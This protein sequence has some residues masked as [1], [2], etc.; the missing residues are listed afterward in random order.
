MGISN[1]IMLVF[2][3]A[4]ILIVLMYFIKNTYVDYLVPSTRL[5][6]ELLSEDSNISKFEKFKGRLIMYIQLL[7]LILLVLM[8]SGLYIKDGAKIHTSSLIFIDNSIS[9][10]YRYEGK[11]NLEKAKAQ[12]LKLIDESI[13]GSS[14]LIIDA[15]GKIDMS[16]GK[17]QAARVIDNIYQLNS[18]L[19]PKA[20]NNIIGG[21][22]SSNP[23][24]YLIIFSNNEEIMGDRIYRYGSMEDN[25]AITKID[26][27]RDNYNIEITN[28]S[29][30]EKN[31]ELVIKLDA[32]TKDI[33]RVSLEPGQSKIIRGK[34]IGE[35]KLLSAKINLD[36]EIHIDNFASKTID[37]RE[38]L[39]VFLSGFSSTYL[40]EALLLN[41]NLSVS[42]SIDGSILNSGFDIYIYSGVEPDKLPK[43]GSMLLIN[44]PEGSKFTSSKVIEDMYVKLSSD[45]LNSFVE[46]FYVSKSKELN[47]NN[48]TNI[49]SLG[50]SPVIQKGK[51]G[52]LSLV[53]MGFD[54]MDT[55]LPLK[56][57]FP[58]Y[59]QNIISYF[60]NKASLEKI[61]IV[62]EKIDMTMNYSSSDELIV[63]S[64]PDIEVLINLKFIIG[65]LVLA[66]L[67]IEV[68]VFKR[69]Y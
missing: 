19:N 13:E 60:D 61:Y 18:N 57:S 25:L 32:N 45:D 63:E 20:I 42:E 8:L 37:S 5:W 12:A 30:D 39:K 23:D 41:E 46:A 59:V 64:E 48:L 53:L 62:S 68:E 52:E 43:T 51:I 56:Y 44:P 24:A 66:L 49:A 47:T 17:E 50:D 31:V 36:D 9:M 54:I 40:R 55:N 15:S 1:P 67:A 33:S 27:Y 11:S 26:T 28:Y 14:F 2:S 3:S 34:I 4:T 65:L 29:L 38:T 22:K 21:Y 6:E 69:E 10:D 35:A 7:I 16:Q 58:I